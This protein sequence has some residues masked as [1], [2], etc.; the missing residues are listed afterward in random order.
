[1]RER[2]SD[3]G[4]YLWPQTS[5]TIHF[6]TLSMEPPDQN[7]P[8]RPQRGLSIRCFVLTHSAPR[9]PF[10]VLRSRRHQELLVGWRSGQRIAPTAVLVPANERTVSGTDLEYK[11]AFAHSANKSAPNPTVSIA[12]SICGQSNL[13]NMGTSNLTYIDGL[14]YHHCKRGYQR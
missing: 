3:G 11:T 12:S 4:F 2:K 5:S 8:R 13:R 9:H 10:R 7:V 1:M 6:E 14:E